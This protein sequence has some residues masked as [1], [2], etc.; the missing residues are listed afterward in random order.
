MKAAVRE[1]GGDIVILVCEE[2]EQYPEDLWYCPHSTQ[3][4]T[5]SREAWEKREL[6]LR[7]MPFWIYK[8]V[9]S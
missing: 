1:V 7:L 3:K 8:R 6:V 9:A 2:V 4:R 5:R